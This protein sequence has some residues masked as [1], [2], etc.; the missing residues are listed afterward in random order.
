MISKFSE[1][2]MKLSDCNFSE[3][4]IKELQDYM[5]RQKNAAL[6]QRFMAILSVAFNTDGIE[7]GIEQASEIFGKHPETI[8]NWLRKYLTEGAEKLNFPS[9]SVIVPVVVPL[10]TTVTPGIGAP[11]S[12]ITVPDSDFCCA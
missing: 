4:D 6:K 12:P 8:K 3:K 10:T 2:I 1:D 5:K 9:M 11:S 7:T